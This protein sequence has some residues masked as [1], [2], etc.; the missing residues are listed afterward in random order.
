MPRRKRRSPQ[1]RATPAVPP[2]IPTLDLHGESAESARRRTEIWLRARWAEGVRTVQVIT[3]R[4][5]HSIGPAVLPA[6]I[7][8]LLGALSGT[9]VSNFTP[10]YEGG[11]FRVELTRPGRPPAPPPSPPPHRASGPPLRDIPPEVLRR[12]EETLW[13]LGVTP[14]PALLRAEARRILEEYGST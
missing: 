4:G 12:A 1:R 8:D 6:A 5:I 11:A 2:R 9:V 13:E 14:T 7:G 3:G 10:E